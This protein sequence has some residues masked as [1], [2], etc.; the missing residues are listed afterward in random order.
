MWPTPHPTPLGPYSP[1]TNQQVYLK[2]P[3]PHPT[4]QQVSSGMARP[5]LSLGYTDRHDHTLEVISPSSSGSCPAALVMSLVVNSFSLWGSAL[6]D[7]QEVSP[8]C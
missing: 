8:L 6:P 3:L 4:N 7:Y 1:P 2:T 5:L